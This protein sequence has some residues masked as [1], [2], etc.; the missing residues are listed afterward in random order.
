MPYCNILLIDDDDDDQEIFLTAVEEVSCTVKCTAFSAATE[1]LQKLASGA[2]TPDVIFLDMN[3][4]VMNGQ[5]FLSEIK[6]DRSLKHIPVIIFTTSTHIPTIQLTKEL[7]AAEFITKPA[8]YDEL[9]NIL[10]PLI[11]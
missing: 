8:R 4:P 3:M 10:T 7:G 9:V 11:R 5:Q 2:I 1:A 6:K